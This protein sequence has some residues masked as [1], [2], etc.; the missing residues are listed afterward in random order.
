MRQHIG[1][2]EKPISGHRRGKFMI[3]HPTFRHY[4]ENLTLPFGFVPVNFEFSRIDFHSRP[5]S[6]FNPILLQ[7]DCAGDSDWR[8]IAPKDASALLS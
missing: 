5:T 4:H 7:S 6:T 8:K 2:S 1:K 3:I